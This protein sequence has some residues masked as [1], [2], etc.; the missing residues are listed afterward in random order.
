[1]DGIGSGGVLPQLRELFKEGMLTH[2]NVPITWFNSSNVY[3]F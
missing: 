3:F 2:E 1:M